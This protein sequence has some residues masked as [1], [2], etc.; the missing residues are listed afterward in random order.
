MKKKIENPIKKGDKVRCIASEPFIDDKRDYM[1]EDNVKVGKE[2]TS[3]ITQ[4]LY[5]SIDKNDKNIQIIRL[6]GF[7][8]CYR[9]SNFEVIKPN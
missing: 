3:A 6:S 1:K 7:R 5:R 8:S 2:Y 4:R 9:A